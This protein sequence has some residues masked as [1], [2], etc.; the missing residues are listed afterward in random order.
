MRNILLFRPWQQG[1]KSRV[2]AKADDIGLAV[3]F[4]DQIRCGGL[5]QFE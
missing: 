4:P 1:G 5:Q 3:Q 2:L